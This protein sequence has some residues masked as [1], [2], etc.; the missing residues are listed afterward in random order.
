MT[1]LFKFA[2]KVQQIS[3]SER[4]SQ[5]FYFWSCKNNAFNTGNINFT[6]GSEKKSIAYQ[7]SNLII[8]FLYLGVSSAKYAILP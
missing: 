2:T 1:L 4:K 7:K 6:V 8:E 5:G 3:Q